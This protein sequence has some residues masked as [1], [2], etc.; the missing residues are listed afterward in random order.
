M[1]PRTLTVGDS[2]R[3]VAAGPGASVGANGT[4][5]WRRPGRMWPVAVAL[6]AVSAT[7]CPRS[8]R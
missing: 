7:W 3:A 6:T 1:L 4:H 8:S 5:R 2:D